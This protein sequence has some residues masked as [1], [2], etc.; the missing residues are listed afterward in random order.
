[1]IN[2][3][4]NF[5][6]AVEGY[7]RKF[8]ARFLDGTRV[9]SGDVRSLKIYK[10]S[11]GNSELIPGA[12]F[13]SYVDAVVDGCEEPL[14]GKELQLQ[15]GV[16]TGGTLE[17][18]V[19]DYLGIGFFTVGKPS[20]SVRRTQFLAYGR[21]AS[22]LSGSY[23]TASQVQTIGE[24]ASQI[25]TDTG[26]LIEFDESINTNLVLRGILANATNRE[27]LEAITSMVGGYATETSTGSVRID[28]FDTASIVS[29]SL[30]RM[31]E[32]PTFQD[33]D[34]EITG[35]KVIVDELEEEEYSS[36]DPVNLEMIRP[37]M[38]EEAFA[39]MADRLI[40]YSYRSG[41][42]LLSLG[43][44]RIEACDTLLI[45][46]ESENTYHVPCMSVVHTY[47][48]G[49][50]TLVEAPTLEDD[51]QVAGVSD[52]ALRVAQTAKLLADTAK[53][54]AENTLIYDHT[55][56]VDVQANSVTFTAHLYR[57]GEDVA[58][59][60]PN[61]QFTWSYKTETE[62][63]PIGTGRVITI[64]NLSEKIGYGLHVIGRFSQ[65][66]EQAL[67]TTEYDALTTTSGNGLMALSETVPSGE[68]VRV[69]DLT[70]TTTLNSSDL[71]MVV[72]PTEEK[73][74]SVQTLADVVDKHYVF[75]QDTPSATWTV[76]HN[77]RKFPAVTVIDSAGTEV[78]G[79]Y[80]HT[81]QNTTVLEFSGAFSGKAYFN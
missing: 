51:T 19:Y 2:S 27:A 40:G 33:Y 73:L 21:I 12:V 46:D 28:V 6:T 79:Q 34:T 9:I 3:S 53:Q 54:T 74:A 18:P 39:E 48:G 4:T 44:P 7:S 13:C 64:T 14:E 58:A 57:G 35:I 69:R 68:S 76:T 62:E 49:F 1:M 52:Q 81:D 30:E 5:Q 56:E 25:T 72:T 45:T 41:E 22:R 31:L 23:Q 47:D 42:V 63:V 29:V 55:Y 61:S 65:I 71:L 16:M 43:D 75:V 32:P 10:G 36:G 50:Q 26:I 60:F 66:E 38:T 17:N 70:V 15:I 59:E 67:M 8:H 77:L 24:V 37:Y 11:S 20:A 80:T 78:I